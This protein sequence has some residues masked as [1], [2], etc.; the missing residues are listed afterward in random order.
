MSQAEIKE[1]MELK[2]YDLLLPGNA[3]RKKAYVCSICGNNPHHSDCVY[4]QALALLRPLAEPCKTCGGSGK[5]PRPKG[6]RHCR[7]RCCAAFTI[8]SCW[9]CQYYVHQESC[10]DCQAPKPRPRPRPKNPDRHL[11]VEGAEEQ[12]AGE[13]TKAV[14]IKAD[15]YRSIYPKPVFCNIALQACDIIDRQAAEIKKLKEVNKDYADGIEKINNACV[16]IR[17]KLEA[18]LD[19]AL[20]ESRDRLVRANTLAAEKAELYVELE[21]G[22]DHLEQA[23]YHAEPPHPAAKDRLEEAQRYLDVWKKER[24]T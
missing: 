11:P 16:K 8:E 4:G 13:F 9:T 15:G 7:L 20:E 14:R 6:Q 1:A 19:K 3:Q 17:R 10:P 21:L 18:E 24:T 22:L 23:L 5:K 2:S 12:E